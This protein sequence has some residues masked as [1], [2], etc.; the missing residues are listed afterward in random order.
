[1]ERI[2]VDNWGVLVNA[3]V[4]FL[5]ALCMGVIIGWI[6]VGLIYNQRLT[7]YQELLANYREVLEDKLPASA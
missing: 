3:P 4:A 6:V 1:M 5:A 7:H 2:L